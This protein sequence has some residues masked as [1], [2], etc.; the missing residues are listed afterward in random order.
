MLLPCLIIY[1]LGKKLQT[2]R[3]IGLTGGI[4]CGKSTL[5]H[6]MTES[7]NDE[8]HV[9]DC[10]RINRGLSAQGNPGYNLIL[11]MLGDLKGEYLTASGEINR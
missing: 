6:K 10:D 2:V 8:I 9:I 3:I 4:A 11:S 5:V 1:F 7:L